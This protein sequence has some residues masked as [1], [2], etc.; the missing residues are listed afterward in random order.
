M[1]TTLN[2][3]IAGVG[4]RMG[5]QLAR[6]SLAA[7]HGLVGGTERPDAPE[8][9]TDIGSLAGAPAPLGVLPVTDVATAAAGADV[10]IDFTA[11]AATLG[12]LEALADTGVRAVIIGT[13]GF[14]PRQ[15]DAVS[16]HGKRFAIVA[17]GNFS[18]G[19]NLLAAVT[20]LVAARLGEGWDAEILETHH[21]RK[22]DAPSG[23]A[24]MLGDA[25]A[26]GRDTILAQVQA[27]PYL[28]ADA[29]RVAGEIGFSVRR[30]GGIVGAHEVT[31]ASETEIVSLGHTALDRSVFADGALAAARWAMAAPA[32]MYDMDDVLR[33]KAL[34]I[35]GES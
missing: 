32:G 24:L 23:T 35:V 9:E 2:I 11:P 12:A 16:A 20:R 27:G 29:E 15:A 28:G 26:A 33:L 7:G 6:A 4:G 25:V 22:K 8:L 13:T 31:F 17:A 21:R 18:L 34:G 19:V 3:A 5:R 30:S 10:W 1:D 14:T